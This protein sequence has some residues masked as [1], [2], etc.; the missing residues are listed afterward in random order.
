[1]EISGAIKL[2]KPTTSH[3]ANNFR[4]RE[5]VLNTNEQYPQNLLIEF[6]QDK[7]D[8]LNNFQAGQQVT[9]SINLRGNEWVSPQGETKYFNTLQGWKIQ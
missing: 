3:G 5:M 7:C 2:I 8:L 6:T 9:V 1:M 4:K